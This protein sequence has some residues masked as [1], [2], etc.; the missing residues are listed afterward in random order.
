MPCSTAATRCIFNRVR[1][2]SS[3]PPPRHTLRPP[4]PVHPH[5]ARAVNGGARAHLRAALPNLRGAVPRTARAAAER[6]RL[7]TSRAARTLRRP[8]PGRSDRNLLIRLGHT[9]SAAPGAG[10][11]IQGDD[12]RVYLPR[13]RCRVARS[14]AAAPRLRARCALPRRRLGD[15]RLAQHDGVGGAP[16]D[17]R[18]RRSGRPRLARRGLP[19]PAALGAC[20]RWR[21]DRLISG[22]L[23]YR[24]RVI[25]RTCGYA[26]TLTDRSYL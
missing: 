25:R 15:D 22:I 9:G 1:A 10:P 2:T 16:E 18:E 3:P 4:Q 7:D 8:R 6:Q 20:E 21:A 23:L 14:D 13:R 17:L 12:A 26:M 19:R 24:I 11:A 5:R